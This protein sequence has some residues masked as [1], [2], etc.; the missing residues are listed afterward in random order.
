MEFRMSR[1]A[2]V[3]LGNFDGVHLGHRVVL[4]RA[5]EEGEKRGMRTIAATF[6]PHPRAVLRPRSAAKLLTTVG[7]RR[8]LLLAEGVDEVAVI[9]FDTELS[10]KSPE[11]FVGEVL[12]ERLGAGLVVVGENFRFGYMAA[13]NVEDLR[14][15]MRSEGGDA[16]GVDVKTAGGGEGISSTRI[17]KLLSDGKIEE[18]SNLLGRSYSL[19]G[20]V[21]MGDGR[22][23]TIGFPT[24]NIEVDPSVL[25][26][27]RGVY[28]CSVLLG[29]DWLP[30][31]ANIGVAP[32]FGERESRVEAHILDFEGDIYGETIEVEFL[33]RIRG[34]KK[35]SGV[36]EL[37][38]RISRD[39]EEARWITDAT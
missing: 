19:R 26:P 30:A 15:I 24:A 18:A 2:V 22:G 7:M 1:S 36:E 35:F 17:R 4:R 23:R 3:A 10:K 28:A 14:R 11:E 37:V 39:V 21:V 20:E 6:D 38:A 33:R 12:V 31:C 27:A 34:E 25:I 5:V 16:I 13:G 8:E 32:T 9:T 29:G